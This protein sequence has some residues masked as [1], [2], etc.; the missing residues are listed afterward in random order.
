MKVRIA[1]LVL[2]GIL[3]ATAPAWSDTLSGHSRDS[4]VVN[5]R[6]SGEFDSHNAQPLALLLSS[7]VDSGQ[8]ELIDRQPEHRL[9]KGRD[10]RDS[11]GPPSTTTSAAAPEPSTFQLLMLGLVGLL[12]TALLRPRSRTL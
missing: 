1:A 2:T 11:G 10:R 12:G 7:F 9:W 6:D 4:T 3:C 5:T 8:F